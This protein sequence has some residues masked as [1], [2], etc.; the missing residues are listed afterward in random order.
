MFYHGLAR[1]R[2]TV[3]PYD[4][5][6]NFSELSQV[7]YLQSG[8]Y[9]NTIHNNWIITAGFELEPIKNWRIF[10]DYIYKKGTTDYDALATPA[11]FIG[12]DETSYKQNTCA[13]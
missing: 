3:S 2:A 9:T 5:N 1:F 8:T 6:G 11:T 12:I 4:L 10:M 7:P 13:P